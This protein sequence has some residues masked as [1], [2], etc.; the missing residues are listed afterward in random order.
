MS[1][2]LLYNL[3]GEKEAKIKLLCRKMNLGSRSVGKSE[4]GK[5]LCS[6]LGEDGDM[7]KPYEDFSDE[8]LYMS[9]LH[10]GMLNLFLDQLR[11]QKLSVPLK[12]IE[13]ETNRT[14]TSYELFR[15]LC[16]ERDAIM[17]GTTAHP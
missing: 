11:R 6:L 3:S 9:G 7:Q 8:M 13:T 5:P 14:F 16:A 10:G 15:E 1:L 12:A 2:I 4:Y 17:K